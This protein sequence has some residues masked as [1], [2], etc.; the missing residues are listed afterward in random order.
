MRGSKKRAGSTLQTMTIFMGA[1][2][3]VGAAATAF[4]LGVAETKGP[5]A[6]RVLEARAAQATAVKEINTTEAGVAPAPVSAPAPLAEPAAKA[7]AAAP[8][9][10]APA[11]YT[12]GVRRIE[13]E[14]STGVETLRRAAN[15]GYAPAQFYLAKLYESGDAGLKK[16]IAEARRWTERAAQAGDRRAMHN[17]GLYYFEGAGGAKNSTTAAQWFRRAADLGLADSQY[18]LARLYE[19]GLGVGKN[20]AEAY[21]WYLI[22]ARNGDAESQKSAARVKPQLSAEAQTAAQRSA[23]GFKPATA[24][25]SQSVLASAAATVGAGGVSTAQ[26]ALSKLGYYQGP[27]DGMMSPALKMAVAAYQRD[28]GVTSTGAL[29]ADILNRLQTFAR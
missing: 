19:E 9:E 20:G 14:D 5:P 1:T 3:A 25:P 15:L 22:A 29:D 4:Y 6:P 23:A 7:P 27:Q 16:D 11:L 10:S 26:K 28:Q 17:L 8:G 13:A 18:N 21:K 24:N 12:E 2:A